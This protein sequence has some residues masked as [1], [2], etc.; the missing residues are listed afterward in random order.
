MKR[1][2]NLFERV[3]DRE[4]LLLA[5][6]KA[7]R[8]KAARPDR[9]AFAANLG[10]E[11]EELRDGLLDGT[12]PVG[13]YSQFTI[14][15]PKERVITAAPFR[16]RVLQHALM[17]ICE[18]LFEK[19]MIFDT[20][21]C[22][23]G[24]GQMAAV[25]RAARFARSN[26]WFLK[27]DFRKYFDSIPHERLLRMLSR[28]FRDPRLLYW[29]GCIIATYE[30]TPGHGLP[31]GNLTSQHFAN[32]YLDSIDRMHSP[33]V[34]YMDDF[35]LW[36]NDRNALLAIRERI[37]SHARSELGLELK[38]EPFLNRTSRGM[39]FL[40]KRVFPGFYQ[41]SRES[42][43]RYVRKL[44]RLERW[45]R[46]GRLEGKDFQARA[47]ALTA[48]VSQGGRLLSWRREVC[49]RIFA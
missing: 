3:V 31:I 6:W 38:G 12:Y 22:R 34:R 23:K 15:D 39:D 49:G 18:P 32:L 35:V 47:D 4:N 36:D 24:K 5:F 17:N 10:L 37:R 43:R 27:C 20:Y 46:D 9:N 28:K 11:I 33:Y 25:E 7:G 30:T 29:F 19:W 8:G 13:D 44:T 14:F 1:I 48:F 42:R 41:P 40:G 2:G 26:E 16:E 45:R 21:A